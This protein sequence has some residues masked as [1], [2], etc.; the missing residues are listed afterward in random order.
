MLAFLHDP[1]GLSVVGDKGLDSDRLRAQLQNLGAKPY[2][3]RRARCGIQRK[4]NKKLY[5]QRYRIE[6]YYGRLKRWASTST[7]RDKLASHFLSLVQFVSVIDWLRH[8]S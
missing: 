1:S 6:N 5:R 2:I 4:V 3:P 7:R 8:L